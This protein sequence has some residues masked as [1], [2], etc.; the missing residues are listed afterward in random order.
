MFRSMR[1]IKL[2]LSQFEIERILNSCK[3]GVL[4][5]IGDMGYPYTIPLNYVYCNGKIYFHCAREGHK[6]DAIRSNPK[7]SFCV[8]EKNDVIEEEFTT[9]FRSA[10]AFG[11]ARIVEDPEERSAAFMALTEKLCPH[12]PKELREKECKICDQAYIVA[13]AVE[14]VTGKHAKELLHPPKKHICES[15]GLP[16]EQEK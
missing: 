7:V 8:V 4:A 3:D 1:R 2:G 11:T 10:V 16:A 6:L 14:H 13:I 15:F 9:Y 12:M 5:V